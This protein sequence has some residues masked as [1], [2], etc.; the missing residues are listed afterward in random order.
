[1]F[2][3]N[4]MLWIIIPVHN[5]KEFTHKCLISLRRQTFGDFKVIV[6]DDGSTDGTKEMLATEFPEVKV[7]TGDGN[8]WWTKATNLG[9]KYALENGADYILTLNNDTIAKEDFLEK[10]IYWAERMPH[11]LL[12]AFAFDAETKEPVSGGEKINWFTAGYI[13]LL[14]IVDNT[15]WRGL[16]EV[17]HFSG[18]GLLIPNK[19]F[20]KIGLFDEK[21]F[22]HYAADYDFTHR[23]RR[24]GFKIYCNYDA[25]IYIYPDI[26]GSHEL[27]NIKNLKN[28]YNHLF[29]RKGGG[30]LKIFTIY[31]IKNCPKKYLLMFLF[32][33]LFKRIFG[34][35]LPED[36]L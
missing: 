27:R 29:G 1:L 36:K 17:T 9:V 25:I 15:L 30:N 34:Y 32:C 19:V 6:I 26:S 11:A 35:L 2:N 20:E 28:Y 24:A 7:L 31:A 10:M 14:D 23:A 4:T 21:Y 16:R 18:R 12:G 3:D 22:P 13:S 33:G 5:R 8:L